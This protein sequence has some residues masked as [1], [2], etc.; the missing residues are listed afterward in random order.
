MSGVGSGIAGG[1]GG[2]N[3]AAATN[4]TFAS[5]ST[6]TGADGDQL[7][8][9]S[10]NND[11]GISASDPNIDNGYNIN[12]VSSSALAASNG[13]GGSITNWIGLADGSGTDGSFIVKTN[14][15]SKMLELKP[16][17]LLTGT[18]AV[19]FEISAAAGQSLYLTA[20]D[21]ILFNSAGHYLKIGNGFL[22][23]P[24]D[25]GIYFCSDSTAA[26][27]ELRYYRQGTRS[28]EITSNMTGSGDDSNRETRFRVYSA[29]GS[30]LRFGL[31]IDVSHPIITIGADSGGAF[32]STSVLRISSSGAQVDFT[33]GFVQPVTDDSNHLGAS[34]KVWRSI[35]GS[36]LSIKEGSN[37]WG[38]IATLVGGTVT[39]NTTVVTA[40]SRIYITPQSVGGTPGWVGISARSVGTSFTITS[41]SGTDTSTVAWLIV[42]PS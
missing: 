9:L 18:A 37:H 28:W 12:F 3:P 23:L 38:G 20:P 22:N 19:P 8:L 15:G 32:A 39:V 16:S 36:M 4:I 35:Y 34:S 17:G 6:I 14:L 24:S 11:I 21:Q 1:G 10:T 33:N 2:F 7:V 40:N 31:D 30:N 29:N 27:P 41:S 13:D 42:E 5:G 26:T 25:G